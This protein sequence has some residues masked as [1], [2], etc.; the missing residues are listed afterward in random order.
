MGADRP[1]LLFFGEGVSLAHVTRPRRILHHLA[2]GPFDLHFAYPASYRPLFRGI[3]ATEHDLF[4]VP[5]EAFLESLHRLKPIYSERRLE[6]YL[7]DDLALI[8]AI[9]PEVVVHDLRPTVPIAAAMRG[10][11]SISIV[12]A[13]YSRLAGGRPEVPDVRHIRHIGLPA[14]RLVWQMAP[15]RLMAFSLGPLA[16][17]RSRHGLKGTSEDL[18]SLF[19]GDTCLFPDAD[20]FAPTPPVPGVQRRIG[21]LQWTPEAG[22]AA[23]EPLPDTLGRRRPLVYVCFGSSGKVQ[24]L[25]DVVEGV[26]RTGADILVATGGRPVPKTLPER[27]NI[28]V[29]PFVNGVEAC[30]RASLVVSNGGNPQ[31]VQA[32][33]AGTPVLGIPSNLDQSLNM[34]H[35]ERTGAARSLHPA[36]VTERRIRL[37]TE[38]LLEDAAP[39]AAAEREAGLIAAIDVGDRVR[40][41]FA[42][43][44]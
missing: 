9:R 42:R 32:F 7:K 1:R 44:A 6:R 41:A 27:S 14:A 10:I 31:L 37:S 3:P 19:R 26:S 18:L 4:S 24:L 25:P 5:S 34:L 20:H 13:Y 11:P 30:R 40:E 28:V 16:R 21:P 33:A 15:A 43:F 36:A 39:K 2:D 23:G 8:D 35:A 12:N 38:A 29:R 22:A 17:F